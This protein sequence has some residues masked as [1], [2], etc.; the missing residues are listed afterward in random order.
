MD[1]DQYLEVQQQL[2]SLARIVREMP[3]GAFVNKIARAEALG[4]I[5]D[6]TLYRQTMDTV[7]ILGRLASALLLFQ[8]VAREIVG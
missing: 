1:N 8:E 4:P 5:V 2:V 7:Q 6:P 3:L